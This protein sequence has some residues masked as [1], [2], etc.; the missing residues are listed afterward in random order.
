MEMLRTLQG[1]STGEVSMHLVARDSP[2]SSPHLPTTAFIIPGG[3]SQSSGGERGARS[4]P[5]PAHAGVDP[6][7]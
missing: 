5:I 2:S 7:R 3:S 4:I 6:G 1:P